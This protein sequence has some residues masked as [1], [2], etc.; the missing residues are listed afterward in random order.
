MYLMSMWMDTWVREWKEGGISRS[1]VHHV[2][3]CSSVIGNVLLVLS[4]GCAG[5]LRLQVVYS[6]FLIFLWLGGWNDK[7]IA[8]KLIPI[9]IGWIHNHLSN[10][11]PFYGDRLLRG[12]SDLL[13][14]LGG[15]V[16]RTLCSIQRMQYTYIAICLNRR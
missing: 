12:K 7:K 16:R 5:S 9:V 6:L 13:K 8:K 14:H 4:P 10:Y 11:V 1:W 2:V 15:G 3:L